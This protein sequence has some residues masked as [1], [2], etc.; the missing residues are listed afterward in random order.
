MLSFEMHLAKSRNPLPPHLGGVLHGFVE[1]GAKNYAAHLLQ[2]LR[3]NGVNQAAHFMIIVPPVYTPIHDVLRFGIVLY[4]AAA[5]AFPVLLRALLEQQA[6][7]IHGRAACIMQAWCLSP[8]H[9]TFT[10]VQQGQLLNLPEQ[11][12]IMHNTHAMRK[13]HAAENTSA[14]HT[15]YF[16]SPLL[17]ASR[18][19][20]RDKTRIEAGLPWPSLASMLNSIAERLR[21]LEPTLAQA[22]GIDAKWTAPEALHH[23]QALTPATD[24]ARQIEWAYTATSRHSKKSHAKPRTLAFRG[25]VGNLIYQ[26]NHTPHEHALLYWGQWLG[27]G[28]KTTM[29]CGN[30]VLSNV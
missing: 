14:L 13:I 3:P 19:A 23:I 25:I 2:V 4:N 5:K 21:L 27:V 17:L 15:L 1:G 10:L 26:N 29:G 16:Q 8:T 22:I 12:P 6:H 28:Q 7:G 20:Q 18:K 9:E 11:S 30:Y 24:P